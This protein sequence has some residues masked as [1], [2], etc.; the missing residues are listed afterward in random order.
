MAKYVFDLECDGLNPTVIWCLVLKDIDTSEVFIYASGL[1]YPSISEGVQRLADADYFIFHNGLWFDLP[2]L[3]RLAS[4]SLEPERA[5]DTLVCSRLFNSWDYSQHGLEA[6]GER[7]GF[8]KTHFNDWSKLT[9][10][11]IDYCVNDV[12]V[13]YRLWKLFEPLIYAP[14]WKDPLRIE[15]DIAIHYREMHE[16]GFPFDIEKAK[17]LR[18]DIEVERAKLD[19]IIQEQF[20]PKPKFLTEIY[21]KVT[22]NGNLSLVNF[23]WLEEGSP[24]EN[25][26]MA[27]APF[28]RISWETFNPASPSQVIE[29]MWEFGWQPTEK[30]KGHI[31][32]EREHD[33]EKLEKFQRSGWKVS[34]ENLNTLPPDAPSAA[35]SLV[36]WLLLNSRVTT[37]TTWIEAYNERTGCIHGEVRHIGTW[38]H[39]AS[40][41]NPNTGNITR[42]NFD[43]DKRVLRGEAGAF[44]ADMRELW[45]CLPGWK[46]V[47]CDAEG[48]QLRV[49]AHYMEDEAFTKALVSGSSKDGTDAHTM[50][51][52]KLGHVCKNRD[53]AKTFIYSWVLG[54]SATKTAQVLN[55]RVGEAV[56]ARK[57]FL[58]GYPGL[59]RLKEEIIPDDA[60]RGYFVGFDGRKVFCDSEHLML[61]GYL[62]NGENL[63]M[64]Y[65]ERLW[66]NKLKEL[67][68]PFKLANMVHDEWQTQILDEDGMPEIAGQEMANSIVQAGI[69]L[70]VKCPQA[71]TPKYGYNWLQTH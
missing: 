1:G 3:N 19:V 31:V 56:V 30:T 24:E 66:Y 8:P 29:R 45:T 51:M 16:N 17:K 22:K 23:K 53:V 5:I 39:R 43:G 71:G 42:V 14:E 38:T 70:G 12:E 40:H 62:Q 35:H 32:A 37:L 59:K 65:A 2:V 60:A 10:E 46:L 25:G 58:E 48:I 69:D 20:P 15:H 55:C 44:G 6:W 64:K 57:S 7:L 47:G 49:L 63:I 36:R 11:M 18:V 21:P 67:K 9:Q 68:I 26:Y 4:A 27:N 50:N 33:W 28:S 34:E 13:N 41:K 61:A 52:R 54:A